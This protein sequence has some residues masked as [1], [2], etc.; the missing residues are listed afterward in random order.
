MSEV[1]HAH[2]HNLIQSV[3]DLWWGWWAARALDGI[4]LNQP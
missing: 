3:I 4:G 2:A 1:N